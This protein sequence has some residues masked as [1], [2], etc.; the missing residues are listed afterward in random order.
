[1]Q[2]QIRQNK[3]TRE[4]VIYSPSR[5]NRPKDFKVGKQKADLPAHDLDCPFCK[6]NENKLPKIIAEL[7]N[8]KSG[9]W[10]TRVV[11]NK[12]P[13][14]EEGVDNK[15]LEEGIYLKMG[16]YGI[17][18]VIIEH[19]RHDLDIPDLSYEEVKLI[20]ET[21]HRR[22]LELMKDHY[23]LM[24]LIF[25]NH[26][27]RAGTSLIHPHSQ[28]IVTNFVPK[29]IREREEQAQRYFDEFGTCVFCDILKYE[30]E[31]KIRLIYETDHF[32]SIIPYAAEVPFE[33]KI[34]PKKHLA[35]FGNISE[36]E[37][38]DF[39]VILRD[40]LK[41][42]CDKLEDPD[43]NYVINTAPRYKAGEPHLHWH[44]LIKPRLTTPA[45]FEIGSGISI[46]PSLPEENAKYLR[47]EE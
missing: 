45:G 34:I 24:P 44:L 4:W 8:P 43:Y 9:D 42:L 31:E 33:I 10:Q 41:L 22:Y 3:A 18:E 47:E 6:G 17:H 19:S 26:G 46:N 30:L 16:G 12:F 32:V 14:L 11:P 27:S 1:M 40:T 35:E 20:I 21:Y 23:H 37:K 25:R 36:E 28:I 2:N 29:Y 39:A 13:A 5:G 38:E 15:R 7:S